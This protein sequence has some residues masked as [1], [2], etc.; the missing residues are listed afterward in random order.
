MRDVVDT[1]V[2]DTVIY[3]G[4]TGSNVATLGRQSRRSQRSEIVVTQP[5]AAGVYHAVTGYE[6]FFATISSGPGKVR[7]KS[8]GSSFS[9]EW[10]GAEITPARWRHGATSLL[11]PDVPLSVI[12]QCRASM[13][14]Q[15]LNGIDISELVGEANQT[16]SSLA[17]VLSILVDLFRA[18]RSG[19]WSRY[20]N[21]TIADLKRMGRGSTAARA[22]L[23]WIYG[24]K[25]VIQDVMRICS[26]WDKALDAP[27]V[28]K[29]S[30]SVVDSSFKAPPLLR[31]EK[32]EGKFERGVSSAATVVLLDP[33]LYKA[34][35]LGLTKPLSV[36]WELTTLSFV[37]DWFLNIGL[38]LRTFEG[39]AGI[40][41]SDYWETQWV[42][43]NWRYIRDRYAEL[44]E[45][46]YTRIDPPG[47]PYD[48]MEAQINLKC[49]LRMNP[50]FLL[51]APL[52]LKWGV[53]SADKALSLF[54]ILLSR[55]NTVFRDDPASQKLWDTRMRG[56][57]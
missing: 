7:W 13:Y 55:V 28:K 23:A 56:F 15:A 2:T 38:F 8:F 3:S 18:F 26:D 6:A 57:V 54:A 12:A 48:K 47:S 19:Q 22:Y 9:V 33:G 50:P 27:K 11:V 51:P 44:Y 29:I 14:T 45:S 43:T 49:M 16:V 34:S 10:T 39:V 41:Y 1:V 5:N 53:D 21:Y 52:Y 42:S 40:G 31:F 36:A 46:P 17:S 32:A 30:S 24:F 4:P 20:L 25:P 37:V 35:K